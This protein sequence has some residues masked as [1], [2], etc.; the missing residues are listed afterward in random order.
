VLRHICVFSPLLLL[1]EQDRTYTSADKRFGGI[2]SVWVSDGGGVP[3]SKRLGTG[4]VGEAFTNHA[5]AKE[6]CS[7]I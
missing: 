2:Y 5:L 1:S 3:E 6:R 7:I 4:P